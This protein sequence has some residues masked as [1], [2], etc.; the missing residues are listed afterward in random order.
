MNLCIGDRIDPVGWTGLPMGRFA[1]PGHGPLLPVAASQD[2]LF[3]WR[4]G[5]SQARVRTRGRL[6][7]YER[8]AGVMDIM[9]A[10]EEA[11]IAHDVP[12]APGECLLVALPPGIRERLGEASVKPGQL[13]SRFGF[14]DAHLSDLVHALEQQCLEGEPWGGLYTESISLALA[15]YLVTRYGESQPY[16]RPSAVPAAGRFTTAL[17][18]RLYQYIDERL[19]SDVSLQM[20]AAFSGYS[21]QHFA[22]LFRNTFNES[23][24]QFLTRLRVEHAKRLLRSDR[25]SLSEIA[26][27]CGFAD[28]SHFSSVFARKTGLPPGR[29]RVQQQTTTSSPSAS[30]GRR[31]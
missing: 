21:Q 2:T 25:D 27:A 16:P 10:D 30:V 15:S 19:A 14:R 11:F 17:Q 18:R 3:V 1:P 12:E 9:A 23:P 7:H 24:H 13:P 28:Q 22:R 29:F 5:A 6:V 26:L 4:D 8:R 31:R 20:L